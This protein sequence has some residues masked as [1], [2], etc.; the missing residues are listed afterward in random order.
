MSPDAHQFGSTTIAKAKTADDFKSIL[1]DPL[2]QSDPIIIKPNWVTD[3]KGTFT[4][5]ETL[6]KV[7]E[8][9]PG[10]IIVV[11]GY[12][13]GRSWNQKPCGE[14]FTTEEGEHDWSWFRGKGWNWL[15]THPDWDWFCNGPHWDRIK[16]EDRLFLD[17]HGFS[18]LLAEFDAEYINVTEEIWSGRAANPKMVRETVETRYPQCFT[19]KLYGIVPERL[20]RLRGATLISLTRLKE[21]NSFTLKNLFGLIPDPIRAWWHGPKDS[22]LS[23]SIVDTAKVYGSFFSLHGVWE[24]GE[25]TRLRNPKGKLGTPGYEFDAVEGPGLLAHGRNLVEMDALIHRL[26]GYD[27][28]GAEHIHLAR[29]VLDQYEEETLREAKEKVGVWFRAG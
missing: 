21:Y 4:T 2:L 25:G 7:F 26:A 1:K 6:R 11:E 12:Q 5:A 14:R 19:D 13:L 10:K 18:D 16:R 9:L 28:D 3:D 29:G 22:R 17:R 8:T 27:E 20:M 15:H 23:Q 24:Y